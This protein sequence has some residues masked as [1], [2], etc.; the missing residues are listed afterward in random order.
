MQRKLFG[1][2]IVADPAICHGQLTFAGTRILVRDVL[3]LVATG[4]AWDKIVW[5]CHGSIPKEAISE[6]VQL[7]SKALVDHLDQHAAESVPA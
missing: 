7:A 5:E 6:A 2:Y 1:H 3:E 4:M